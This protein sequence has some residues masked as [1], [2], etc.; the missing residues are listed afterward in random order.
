MEIRFPVGP[1]AIGRTRR[2]SLRLGLDGLGSEGQVRELAPQAG[3][4]VQRRGV[5]ESG[6]GHRGEQARE[7]LLGPSSPRSHAGLGM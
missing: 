1:E 6:M 7:G 5:W 3:A 2:R 4:Q